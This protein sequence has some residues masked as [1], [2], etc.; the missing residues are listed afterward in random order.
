MTA[1]TFKSWGD[2]GVFGVKAGDAVWTESDSFLVGVCVVTADATPFASEGF[3][4]V[5]LSR[6]ANSVP[7]ITTVRIAESAIGNALLTGF[8]SATVESGA[9]SAGSGAAKS[10]VL[11]PQ[12][13]Q[14]T[15]E[16]TPCAGNSMDAPHCWQGHFKCFV[17]LMRAGRIAR[18]ATRTLVAALEVMK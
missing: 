6:K 5:N 4:P 9:S 14:G 15:P 3:D 13:G 18:N 11:S 12:W 16:P 8:F 1:P 2:F 10:V 17:S 7:P